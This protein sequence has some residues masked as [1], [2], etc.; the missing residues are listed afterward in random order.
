MY[1]GAN[2]NGELLYQAQLGEFFKKSSSTINYHI[3]K[4]RKEGLL[5]DFLNLTPKGKKLFRFLW[6]NTNTK[7]IRVHNI[8]VKF[9]LIKCP[10]RYITK[11]SDEIFSEFTNGKYKGLKGELDG[12]TYMIYSRKKIICVIPDIFADTGEQISA[13]LQSIV[14][15]LKRI[16]EK[17]FLG[18]LIGSHALSKIQTSHIAII[19][20]FIAKQFDLQNINYI[21]K[22]IALD[23]SKGVNELELINPKT[24]LTTIDDLRLLDEKIR[25][26][27]RNDKTQKRND[28]SQ[29][30]S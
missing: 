23:K 27:Y 24:N 8:S 28:G 2:Q 29:S 4:F 22:E 15:E 13:A 11:Y 21:G 14:Q 20:A 18:I 10:K 6:K 9:D 16:I 12:I 25:N 30:C 7:I 26:L 19:D 5:S 1:I 17:R 3:L